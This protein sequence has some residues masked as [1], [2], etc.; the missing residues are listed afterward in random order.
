[1]QKSVYSLVLMDD[2]VAAVDRL[3]YQQGTSRSNMINRILAEY[4]QMVTPEQR[5]Q[6]IFSAISAVMNSQSA[7]QPMLSASEAMYSVRSALQ[8]KYNPSVRYVVELYP[9]AGEELG[10]FRAQLRTQNPTLLLYLSQF[11]KLWAKL[12]NACLHG[13]QRSYQAS[14]GRYTRV[15]RTPE[16]LSA[17]QLGEALAS[18]VRLFDTCLKA[19]FDD[20]TDADQA[21]RAVQRAYT[22]G[23]DEVTAQL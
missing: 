4:T 21:V 17:E 13:P 5:M 20:L 10:E 12:E 9:H 7:L 11:Y 2:V 15:L 18:Y 14:S 22:V 8:Y 16:D 3:A 6:D 19:F 1:M 23:L